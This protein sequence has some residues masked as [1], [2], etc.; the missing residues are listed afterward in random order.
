[1]NTIR[2][3][4]NRT[5]RVLEEKQVFGMKFILECGYLRSKWNNK[6]EGGCTIKGYYGEP[7]EGNEPV[8]NDKT[9]DC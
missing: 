2:V 3:I 8:V 5:G 6:V 4:E 9:W 7:R 1:M